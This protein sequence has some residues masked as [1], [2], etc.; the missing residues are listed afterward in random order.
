M[1][2]GLPCLTVLA[3]L[4]VTGAVG[5]VVEIEGKTAHQPPDWASLPGSSRGGRDLEAKASISGRGCLS[6]DVFPSAAAARSSRCAHGKPSFLWSGQVLFLWAYASS[7]IRLPIAGHQGCGHMLLMVSFT[8]QTLF[9]L[10]EAHL[11]IFCHLPRK[12]YKKNTAK[13][14][15]RELPAC[16]YS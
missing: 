14:H 5:S 16:V 4:C 12:T 7:C 11:L 2:Q 15:I 9:H 1:V 6:D 13:T 3:L 8:L 10:M